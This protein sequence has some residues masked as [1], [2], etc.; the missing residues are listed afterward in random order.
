[1]KK[2]YKE[3]IQTK[4]DYNTDNGFEPLFMPD[5]LF[6]YQAYL[7]DLALRRGR[8]ALYTDCGTGKSPMALVWAQNVIQKTNKPVLLLTPVTVVPQ[9]IEEARKFDIEAKIGVT[10][11]NSTPSYNA[12]KYIHVSNYQKLHYF[13]SNDYSGIVL[14]ESSILK[15]MKGKTRVAVTE[16]MKGILYRLLATATAAPNDWPELLSSSEALGYFGARDAQTKF[17]KRNAQHKGF[18]SNTKEWELKR[19]A[20]QGPFWKWI[21][22]WAR[23][24]RNPSDLGFSD[25]G[26]E[27]PNL[28]E[29]EHLVE[30]NRPP[31]GMLMDIGA[32]GWQEER[33]VIKRTI[34]ERCQTV[35]NIIKQRKGVSFVGCHLNEEGFLLKKL[36]P[37]SVEI[38]GRHSDEQKIET[39]QWFKHGDEQDRVLISKPSIFGFGHNFQHCNHLTYFPSHSYESYYQMYRRFLR[40]GQ[41]KD[42]EIDWIYT[43]GGAGM[44]KNLK[45]KAIVA[46]R[47]FVELI[48]HMDDEL[49][50]KAVYKKEKVSLPEWI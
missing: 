2:T 38:A 26:F 15:N 8:F 3:F 25:K 14:D 36:I 40:F 20:E 23:A 28:I 9:M 12:G 37:N 31:D 35:A 30:P 44:V 32:I 50:I 17:F 49:K 33:E 13:N 24:M 45:Q 5:F 48:N 39:V 29:R 11:K 16:F 27:L 10:I 41:L 22:S 1:M 46:D 34:L 4:L 19:W 7:T 18:Y 43:T 47:L 6:D 42:V 21:A